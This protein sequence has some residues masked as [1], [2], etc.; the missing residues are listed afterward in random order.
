MTERNRLLDEIGDIQ[1]RL[2]VSGLPEETSSL[3]DYN[4]TL[5]QLR[6]FAFVFSRGSAPISKVAE[7]LGI[8]PNVAS[9]IVQRLVDR[10]WIE[11]SEDPN[12]RRVRMLAL[13]DQGQALVDELSRIFLAKTRSLL[14]RLTEPQLQA[15]RDVFRAMA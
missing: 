6:V 10:G 7:A 2:L 11:R 12:D 4:M 9:G 14:D 8:K 5:Q 13:T 3:L 1:I 15:L